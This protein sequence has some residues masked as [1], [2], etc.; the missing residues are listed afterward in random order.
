MRFTNQFVSYAFDW[1]LLLHGP[2]RDLA[3]FTNWL[4]NS[5][6]SLRTSQ[7]TC[8][9]RN[10]VRNICGQNFVKSTVKSSPGWG[11]FHSQLAQGPC[12]SLQIVSRHPGIYTIITNQIKCPGVFPGGGDGYSWNWLV[13]YCQSDILGCGSALLSLTVC[14]WTT[15]AHLK[16]NRNTSKSFSD[17]STFYSIKAHNSL[18]A[19]LLLW[20]YST[21]PNGVFNYMEASQL[22]CLSYCISTINLHILCQVL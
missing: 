15:C 5:N 11:I 14:S 13:H 20:S 1:L 2:I 10:E 16:L 12:I 7:R 17:Q 4:V 18:N 9:L 21:W 8:E 3:L 22:R 19:F 6:M